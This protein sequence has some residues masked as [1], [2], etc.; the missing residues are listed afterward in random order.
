[1]ISLFD[2]FILNIWQISKIITEIQNNIE[3]YSKQWDQ[4]WHWEVTVRGSHLDFE[5]Q[6]DCFADGTVIE[7]LANKTTQKW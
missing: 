3:G 5:V 4:S 1:M 2:E 7:D 6:R